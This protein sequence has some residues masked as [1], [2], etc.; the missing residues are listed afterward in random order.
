MTEHS[1]ESRG[2]YVFGGG[3]CGGGWGVGGAV[4]LLAQPACIR[5]AQL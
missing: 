2:A 4:I 1:V 3:V 5:E